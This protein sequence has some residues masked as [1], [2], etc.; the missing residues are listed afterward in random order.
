MVALKTKIQT[1]DSEQ[2]RKG[3][4][5]R[6]PRNTST[7][8]CSN[9]LRLLLSAY[10]IILHEELRRLNGVADGLRKAVG[11]SSDTP[12]YSIVQG[13][14]GAGRCMKACL[15]SSYWLDVSQHPEEFESITV[16]SPVLHFLHPFIGTRQLPLPI[17][18]LQVKLHLDGKTF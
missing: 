17:I 16:R 2:A 5:L 8:F 15:S 10:R 18:L 12:G 9:L 1:E 6:R 11:K 7:R 4:C 14:I 3:R 13:K